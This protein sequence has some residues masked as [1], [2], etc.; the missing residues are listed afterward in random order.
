MVQQDF[1]DL[2]ALLKI[3]RS[4]LRRISDPQGRYLNM[5]RSLTPSAVADRGGRGMRS[6]P[7]STLIKAIT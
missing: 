4:K 3:L 2:L 5:I 6:L 1:R 7:D